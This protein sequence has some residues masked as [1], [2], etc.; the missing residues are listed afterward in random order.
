LGCK[1]NLEEPVNDRFGC[2]FSADVNSRKR[3]FSS[4]DHFSFW[5]E[6]SSRS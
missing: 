6:P 2:L 3:L 5:V 4:V 1:Q